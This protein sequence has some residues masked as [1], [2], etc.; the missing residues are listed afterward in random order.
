MAGDILQ[1]FAKNFRFLLR[2]ST[3]RRTHPAM[4][5]PAVLA[6]AQAAL[7][8]LQAASAA[9]A[10]DASNFVPPARLQRDI[11]VVVVESSSAAAAP[12]SSSSSP[13]A[14]VAPREDAPQADAAPRAGAASGTAGSGSSAS[15]SSSSSSSSVRW[16]ED[17]PDLPLEESAAREIQRLETTVRDLTEIN[18]RIMAQNIALLG[19]LE[20]A[21]RAVRDLRGEKDV[22]ALQLR[23]AMEEREQAGG[24]GAGGVPR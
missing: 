11:P 9:A 15:S 5:T 21:Q 4:A 6:S 19:D 7:A 22:L 23:R 12:S 1:R 3:S 18:D 24:A 16:G 13:A 10:P 14:P 8:R 20:A 17:V 2:P